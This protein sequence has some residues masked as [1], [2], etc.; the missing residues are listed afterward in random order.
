VGYPLTVAGAGPHPS[1]AD[2]APPGRLAQGLV[3]PD[4]D[5]HATADYRRHLVGVL[6]ERTLASAATEALERAA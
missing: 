4:S 5:I 3:D 6:T 1:A 2:W